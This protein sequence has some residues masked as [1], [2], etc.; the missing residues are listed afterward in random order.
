MIHSAWELTA[1]PPF[2][3]GEPSYANLLE[4]RGEIQRSL[5]ITK[6]AWEHQEFSIGRHIA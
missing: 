4:Q 6:K 2:W 3:L 5:M 1:V